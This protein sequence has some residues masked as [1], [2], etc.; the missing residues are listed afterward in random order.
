MAITFAASI[1]SFV[2]IAIEFCAILLCIV[3]VIN[4]DP[5]HDRNSL[6]SPSTGLFKSSIIG[7]LN[8]IL[9]LFQYRE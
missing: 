1:R 7:E 5:S 4:E 9:L 3:Y 6:S 2:D 8:P